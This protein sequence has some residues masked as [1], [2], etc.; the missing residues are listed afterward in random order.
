MSAGDYLVFAV[1]ARD[2]R[3]R[4]ESEPADDDSPM[5]I[6]EVLAY[7]DE[8]ETK[9]IR[10][11]NDDSWQQSVASLTASGVLVENDAGY[12]LDG[13]LHDLAREIVADH[14]H[15]V[16]RFDFLD[17]Q[18]LVREVSLYPTEGAVYRLGTGPDGAVT[19]QELSMASLAD[20][21]AGV[22]TTLPSILNP[23]VPPMLKNP[24]AR[25]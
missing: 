18:W 8:P 22:I 7:F 13:S 6:D 12:E 16:T 17:E 5:S 2:L 4:P 19:I 14:Q 23:D 15:T 20:V 24:T 11:P 25:A 21:L 1:F 10:T 9:Y 3:S